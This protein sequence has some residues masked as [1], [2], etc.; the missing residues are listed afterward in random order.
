MLPLTMLFPAL[1]PITPI[2][3]AGV[4]PVNAIIFHGYLEEA[5]I[6]IKNFLNMTKDLIHH[7]T[8]KK[9]TNLSPYFFCFINL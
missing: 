3:N 6:K 7:K 8:V 5:G 1:K 4:L 2:K 9:V